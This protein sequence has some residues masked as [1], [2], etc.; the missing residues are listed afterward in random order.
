MLKDKVSELQET[1]SYFKELWQKFIQ[2]QQD[3]F[4]PT[5]KYDEII[6]ELYNENVID[7]NDLDKI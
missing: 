1:L 5:D 6:E 7:D 4:F 2:F 3:K